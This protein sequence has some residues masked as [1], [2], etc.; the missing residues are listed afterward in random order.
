MV[1]VK[2]V[3]DPASRIADQ[4]AAAPRTTLQ[5]AHSTVCSTKSVRHQTPSDSSRRHQQ[6]GHRARP[7]GSARSDGRPDQQPTP[8]PHPQ[9]RSVVVCLVATAVVAV[10]FVALVEAFRWDSQPDLI[11]FGVLLIVFVGALIENA[12]RFDSM[13]DAGSPAR[14]SAVPA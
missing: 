13:T 6:L 5:Q 4:A 14:S 10:L 2:G 12:I 7:T 8:A 1:S 11:L 3:T 9:R